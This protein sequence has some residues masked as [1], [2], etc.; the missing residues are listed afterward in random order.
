[1]SDR[2]VGFPLRLARPDELGV[3]L[4]RCHGEFLTKSNQ[5]IFIA[6]FARDAIVSGVESVIAD[7][8]RDALALAESSGIL[9]RDS[10]IKSYDEIAQSIADRSS[11]P[12]NWVCA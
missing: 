9:R 3:A 6:G 4:A 8:L 12:A 2:I 5:A 10:D 1:M 7:R 11:E